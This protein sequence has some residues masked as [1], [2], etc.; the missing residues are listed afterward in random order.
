MSFAELIAKL[1]DIGAEDLR[2]K[3]FGKRRAQ[4][5]SMAAN[6]QVADN[7]K[8]PGTPTPAP[9]LRRPSNNPRYVSKDIKSIVWQRDR[10]VC[11]GC[12]TR[13]G[14]NFDHIIPV[15]R[16]GQGTPDNLQLL[17]FACNQRAWIKA[18]LIANSR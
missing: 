16:G 18:G 14:L 10:G 2:A 11:R 17:C 13:R 12:G 9:E 5:M 4:A 3:K 1:A 7:V 6:D 8:S 15:A